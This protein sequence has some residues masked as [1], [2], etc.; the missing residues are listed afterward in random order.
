[1]HRAAV[2][3]DARGVAEL[4]RR[5]I[6]QAGVVATWDDVVVPVLESLGRRWEATGE[7]VEIEHLFSEAASLGADR[8]RPAGWPPTATRPR[9]C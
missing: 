4:I 5:Q 8:R 9:C 7:G 1:M 2:S 3:L 6:A